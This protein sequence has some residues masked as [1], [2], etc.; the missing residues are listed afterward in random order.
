LIWIDANLVLALNIVQISE[1]IMFSPS[2]S[3]WR[4]VVVF[5]TSLLFAKAMLAPPT[6]FAAEDASTY[7]CFAKD[8]VSMQPDGTLNR[9]M[10]DQEIKSIDKVVIDLATGDVTFPS[11]G[12][13]EKWA[14]ERMPG[15]DNVYVLYPKSD[16]FFSG[17]SVAIATT[18]FIR[19]R[20][21]ADGQARFMALLL[22]N[23]V[24]GTCELLPPLDE[25]SLQ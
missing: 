15:V 22:S 14:I 4:G 1:R 17:N 24:T 16:S 2:V 21:E 10:A 12:N 11:T 19:L 6:V 20:V 9:S 13:R 3:I 23:L 7:R 5:G 18:R 25:P 8:S